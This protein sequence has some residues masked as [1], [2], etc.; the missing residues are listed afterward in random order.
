MYA[1]V[2]N[3][4]LGSIV[5]DHRRRLA[6]IV[7]AFVAGLNLVGLVAPIS[8]G[9]SAP[10]DCAPP[11]PRWYAEAQSGTGST[12]TL[13]NTGTWTNW[14]VPD[15]SPYFTNEAVWII[16]NNNYN[17]SVELGFFSGAGAAG[18]GL[19]TNGILPYYTLNAGANE[20]DGVGIFLPAN[21]G[22]AIS[23]SNKDSLNN[24]FFVG[25]PSKTYWAPSVQYSISWPLL[26]YMQGEVNCHDNWMGGGQGENFQMYWQGSNGNWFPWGYMSNNLVCPDYIQ[27]PCP[28][29]LNQI[30]NSYWNNGGYGNRNYG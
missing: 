7:V 28:Y 2:R 30:N 26:G 19:F 23:V 9:A 10:A 15:G 17:N 27:L 4:L 6:K 21:T 14:S 20:T 13:A 3:V 25:N 12:G 16:N 29:S 24:H 8:A 1:T 22:M 5:K 18:S 11:P